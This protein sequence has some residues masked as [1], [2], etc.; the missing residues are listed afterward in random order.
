[1][2]GT[3]T[4][5]GPAAIDTEADL[6]VRCQ[7]YEPEAIAEFFERFHDVVH[8]FLAARTGD[9]NLTDELTRETFARALRLLSRYRGR[10]AGL[11]PWLLRV[12]NGRLITRR[13][14]RSRAEAAVV[15]PEL[16]PVTGPEGE[17][18][19]FRAALDRLP[20]DQQEVLALRFVAHLPLAVVARALHR[21]V[22]SV[23]ATQ[24]RGLKA[25]DRLLGGE[26]TWFEVA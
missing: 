5:S 1:M 6:L 18:G 12:A 7:R 20:A 15:V 11:G 24:A 16:P 9:P 4:L 21:G 26:P 17:S 10:G 22:G 2:S 19:R 3:R 25:M 13:Q 14:P 23:Q 8:A